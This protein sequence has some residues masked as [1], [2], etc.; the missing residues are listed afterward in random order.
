MI[1]I[2]WTKTQQ[3]RTAG[4]HDSLDRTHFKNDSL[5]NLRWCHLHCHLD[6][7]W[8]QALYWEPYPFVYRPTIVSVRCPLHLHVHFDAAWVAVVVEVA[9]VAVSLLQLLMILLPF[10]IHQLLLDFK[11]NFD[12]QKK[13]K[14]RSLEINLNEFS[15]WIQWSSVC[16]ILFFF[17]EW[18]RSF[19]LKFEWVNCFLF[20]TNQRRIWVFCCW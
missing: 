6:P 19:I 1:E 10:L 13:N 17:L 14:S 5:S 7:L 9:A 20:S 4:V 15:K 12:V 16:T 8:W 18:K 2:E 3:L 11:N